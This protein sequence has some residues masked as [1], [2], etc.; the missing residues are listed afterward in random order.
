ML[1]Q[2]KE[3]YTYDEFGNQL[4]DLR[5]VWENDEWKYFTRAINIYDEAGN[6]LTYTSEL[7]S[8]GE[9]IPNYDQ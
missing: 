9:W 3:I 1:R 2:Y 5:E 8:C 4:S 6:F 7:F